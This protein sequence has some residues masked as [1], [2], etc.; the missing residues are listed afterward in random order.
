MKKFNAATKIL[1]K[2]HG[3]KEKDYD[4]SMSLLSNITIHKHNNRK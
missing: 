1:M 3:M 4:H 2:L